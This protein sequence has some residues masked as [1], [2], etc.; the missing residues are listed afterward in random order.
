[1]AIFSSNHRSTA[2]F[3]LLNTARV[4]TVAGL[5]FGTVAELLLLVEN[6]RQRQHGNSKAG[7]EDSDWAGSP[8][9]PKAAGGVFA[10]AMSRC[11]RV[12]VLLAAVVS[13]LPLPE[14]LHLRIQ[15]S[16]ELVFRPFAEDSG[17]GVLGLVAVFFGA[18]NLAQNIYG[19]P[20]IAGWFLLIVGGINLLLGVSLRSYIHTLRSFE[21]LHTSAD[22]NAQSLPPP[23]TDKSSFSQPA[24]S[25]IIHPPS[26]HPPTPKRT[27]FALAK[28]L[29]RPFSSHTATSASIYSN[30]QSVEGYN[31]QEGVPAGE[32]GVHPSMVVKP[33]ARRGPSYPIPREAEWGDEDRQRLGPMVQIQR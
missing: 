14:L 30:D 8:G 28:T 33:I 27:R 13:E 26:S 10:F 12:M 25:V 11:L 20:R 6:L 21:Y 18:E 17:V 16:F 24:N 7:L 2:T 4:L 32:G 9:I 19:A 3:I 22:A 5:L 1:M 23:V 31:E 15:Q 29:F